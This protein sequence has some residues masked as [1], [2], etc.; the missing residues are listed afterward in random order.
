M[1]I[2]CS[3]CPKP[4]ESIRMTLHA[5]NANKA[6]LPTNHPMPLHED[7]IAKLAERKIFSKKGPFWKVQ[8]AFW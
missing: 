4:D 1:G 6:I 7:I 5:H 3:N 8:S 2:Q